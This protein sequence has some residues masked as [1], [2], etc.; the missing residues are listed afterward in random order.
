MGDEPDADLADFRSDPTQTRIEDREPTLDAVVGLLSGPDEAIASHV[1]EALSLQAFTDE[2][3]FQESVSGNFA[4]G[5][6]STHFGEETLE[7]VMRRTIAESP[8]ARL[9]VVGTDGGDLLRSGLPSDE[10]AVLPADEDEFPTLVKRLYLRAYLSA[11]IERY[12]KVAIAIRNREIQLA[13]SKVESDDRLTRL[14]KSREQLQSYVDR[15]RQ[16]LAPADIRAMKTRDERLAE[17]AKGAKNGPDPTVIGL[18]KACPGCRLDWTSWHGK[19][20]ANGFTSIG[21]S[22]WQC[23]RCGKILSDEDPNNYQI[24]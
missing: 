13:T 22:T 8:P 12:Y 1:P 23:T 2:A 14:R 15:F 7:T 3:A 11:T 10:E 19:R 21:A 4:V 5:I 24:G 20:L 6:L 17:L 18:P 9:L 16:A